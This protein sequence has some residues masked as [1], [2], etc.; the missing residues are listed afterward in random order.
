MISEAK[1]REELEFLAV[2]IKRHDEAYYQNDM[3]LISDAEYDELR[4]RNR[5]L[6]AQFPH[7][8]RDDSPEARVGVKPK[9]G[10]V[11]VEHKAPMLSLS[12]AFS[13]GDVMDFVKRASKLL[14]RPADF[15]VI[16]EPKIDGLSASVHYKNGKL[17]LGVTRGD[18]KFGEDVTDNIRTVVDIPETLKGDDYPEYLE[19]RGEVYMRKDDFEAL[20]AARVMADKSLYANP[21]NSAAGSLRQLDSKVT[22]ARKLHFF[23]YAYGAVEGGDVGSC[24]SEFLRKLDD[25]G[26]SVNF[27]MMCGVVPGHKMDEDVALAYK[28]MHETRAGLDYDIDGIVFKVD[29]FEL[30]KQLGFVSRAP[31]WAIARKFPAEQ[32]I[33]TLKEI[34]IQVGRTGSLTPVA[35]LEPVT[36]GGVVVSRATLHNEDEIRRLDAREGD[37]VV[38]QRAGDVIPQVVEVLLDRRPEDSQM[39]VF[40]HICPACGGRT[41]RPL[42]EVIRRC[43]AGMV[44]SA[45]KV[46]QIKH[47]V[48]RAAFD[49]D[50]FG[51][52]K[53]EMLMENGLVNTPADIF[54]LHQHRNTIRTW[55]RWGDRSVEKLM[56]SIETRRTISL[57]KFVYGLGIRSVG[58]TTAKSL[59]R[60][61]E[62]YDNWFAGMLDIA[63]GNEKVIEEVCKI[64]KIGPSLI[65]DVGL[66]F[67][68]TQ[69]VD[70][71]VDLANE[72]T[73]EET[74]KVAP[75]ASS[76]V[77]GM[78]IVFTGSLERMS[79]NEAKA[80]AETLGAKV[81]G[82]VSKKTDL[83]VAG[84]G[85]GSK[86]KK[87]EELGIKMIDEDAWFDLIGA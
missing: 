38:I 49:I 74:K 62:T 84:P 77:A 26:F 11:R 69:N 7:L 66:F 45:Q 12:N 31:R 82:G 60:H 48:S 80:Q 23:A 56:D 9:E 8:V 28:F 47:F 71:I 19:V 57:E 81:S 73:I 4:I 3:P 29:S 54:R 68:E 50:G 6:E 65:K 43:T 16:A 37:T 33:T 51:G 79:R 35:N 18:G 85:A 83:V 30:Q 14:N 78:V 41:A 55:D 20:N 61:F 59:A 70:A 13:D 52:S 2:E 39:F 21:R 15:A 17:V 10:F 40:P 58:S 44:C 36:V 64:E 24:Q 86:A 42:G 27:K 46:N 5:A 34:T 32:A 22:A 25:W 1:A 75:P 53:V 87:A 72:L 63:R 76:S 67:N